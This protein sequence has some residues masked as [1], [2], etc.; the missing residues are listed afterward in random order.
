MIRIICVAVLCII[1]GAAKADWMSQVQAKELLGG[2]LEKG[3]RLS[4]DV[5]ACRRIS[6]QAIDEFHRVGVEEGVTDFYTRAMRQNGCFDAYSRFEPSAQKIGQSSTPTTVVTPLPPADVKPV[7]V[8]TTAIRPPHQG[9]AIG[10]VYLGT[11]T[12]GGS[13]LVRAALDLQVVESGSP[14]TFIVLD[15]RG[16]RGGS[17]SEA[18]KILEL[19]APHQG[20]LL[21]TQTTASGDF[22]N[23]SSKKG[24]YSGIPMAVLV[25]GDT[26]SA[27]ETIAGTLRSW[28][29]VLVGSQTFG[30]FTYQSVYN[31]GPFTTVLTSGFM[32]MGKEKV[33]LNGKGLTPDFGMEVANTTIA[34]RREDDEV[35]RRA[36]QGL[37]TLPR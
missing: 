15:M 12:E 14:L 5:A 22:A 17:V 4:Q 2:L 18:V 32:L 31:M 34:L 37:Y 16:N 28:G 26:G 23:R 35:Y 33:N 29:K 8:L 3:P 27:A 25:N 24:A 9:P 11:I 20:A 30:K 19:F 7:P 13:T 10:Y 6:E 21:F 36:V 1:S